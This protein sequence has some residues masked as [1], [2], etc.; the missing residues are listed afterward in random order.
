MDSCAIR[1]YM[2]K[3][4]DRNTVIA[5]L[6]RFLQSRVYL[7]TGLKLTRT[8]EFDAPLQA[9][10]AEFQKYKKLSATDGTLNKET[11]AALGKEMTAVQLRTVSTNHPS[12]KYLLMDG[13]RDAMHPE[14]ERGTLVEKSNGNPA[15]EQ[16]DRELAR[17]FTKDRIVRAVSGIRAADRDGNSHFR[18]ADGK[19]YTMHIYGDETG[20][21]VTG[22]YLPR[23]LLNP[24]YDGGDTVYATTKA[25]EVLGIAHVRVSSQAQLDRNYN[26]GKVNAAGSRYIG[27][28]AGTDGDSVCNRHS[29]LHFFPSA[30]ARQ[31]IK[32]LKTGKDGS[33]DPTV[34]NT[35]DLLDVREL[36]RRHA[37][38]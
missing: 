1:Y 26:S 35:K 36:L 2:F 15:D 37:A 23:F 17:L 29:H 38:K 11:Y 5:A 24:T 3:P 8:A 34:A 19:V 4:G 31:R 27:D 13:A 25:G 33:Q 10:L 7:K 28:I 9:T 22:I 18:L 32:A 14:M 16:A 6:K 20:T 21:E 30:A 12:L